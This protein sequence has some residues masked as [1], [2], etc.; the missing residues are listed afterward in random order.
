LNA[1]D[2]IFHVRNGMQKKA[3]EQWDVIVKSETRLFDFRFREL[4]K[5]KEL[6]AVLVKRDFVSVYKQTI[7]GPLWFVIQP[8]MTTIMYTFVFG[9][10]AKMSTSG[11]PQTLFYFS[12]T[13]LWTFFST[14]LIK[15]SDTFI[16]NAPMFSKIYFPR[17]ALP[18]S[19]VI[20]HL[21]T[22]LIQL[23]VLL[24]LM[25][26]FA[27]NGQFTFV[28]SAHLLLIPLLILQTTIL[29]IGVGI[30]ISAFT[31]KYR[32]LRH[33]VT[34]GITL[35]MYVTPVVY[36]LQQVPAKFRALYK[37]NPVAP[38]FEAFRF[39]LLGAG[40][41]SWPVWGVSVAASILV[42][43]MGVILFNRTARNFVDVI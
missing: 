7:L 13:M 28:F 18:L 22:F 12:G 32:D 8:L 23:A 41:F 21:R 39:S 20:T 9:N 14:N 43:L 30:L 38:I 29:S 40:S 36:P 17:L 19:Y 1:A 16:S 2:S 6:I 24:V 35:W 33:L 31:T 42:F 25:G 26:Y 5:S 27:A 34:F 15:S 11:L 4:F 37:V 10:I 3:K